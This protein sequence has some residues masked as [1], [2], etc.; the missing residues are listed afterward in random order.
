MFQTK[1][2]ESA[3]RRESFMS[4]FNIVSS[5]IKFTLYVGLAGGLVDMTRAMMFKA[6]DAHRVGLVSLTDLNRQLF[7]H[8]R[9]HKKQKN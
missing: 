5:L 8:P 1:D 4:P 9:N 6:A 3:L 2:R 7:S